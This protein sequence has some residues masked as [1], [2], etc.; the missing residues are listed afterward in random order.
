[1]SIGPPGY[2]RLKNTVEGTSASSEGSE[3][4]SDTSG[5]KK[6]FWL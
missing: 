1:M 2:L 4:T 5:E 3:G 6:F